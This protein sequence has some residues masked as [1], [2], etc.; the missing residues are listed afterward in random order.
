MA[1]PLLLDGSFIFIFENEI[2]AVVGAKLIC[3]VFH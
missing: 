2:F 1:N 3:L